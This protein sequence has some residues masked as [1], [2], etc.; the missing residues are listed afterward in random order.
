MHNEPSPIQETLRSIGES[1]VAGD[2]GKAA[3]Q[4]AQALREGAVDADLHYLSGLVALSAGQPEAAVPHFTNAIGLNDRQPLYHLLMGRAL[5][6]AGKGADAAIALSRALALAPASPDARLELAALYLR[7]G[8]RQAAKEA[9]RHIGTLPA[10]DDESLGRLG[11][12][13]TELGDHLA[14]IDI[15]RR[16]AANSPHSAHA[17]ADLGFSLFH[18]GNPT[19][20]LEAL[21]TAVRIAPHEAGHWFN[22]GVAAQAVGQIERAGDA[23]RFA[24]TLAPGHVDA[25]M[26]LGLLQMQKY[27]HEGARRTFESALRQS[28]GNSRLLFNLAIALAALGEDEAADTAF[29]Q[30]A[31]QDGNGLYKALHLLR[32]PEVVPVAEEDLTSERSAFAERI[33]EL[34]RYRLSLDELASIG[35]SWFCLAYHGRNNRDLLSGLCRAFRSA[36]PELAY[37]ARHCAAPR[38]PGRIRV[39]FVSNHL[40]SHTVGLYFVAFIQVLDPQEF[41]VSVFSQREPAHAV[42]RGIH[43]HAAEQV[44]LARS[45]AVARDQ[46][47]AKDLDIL[48]YPDIGMEPMSYFMAFA[49]LAP[50]QVALYGHPET[51]GIDTIDRFLSHAE[52]ETEG[53]AAHYSEQLLLMPDR[54]AYT[55]FPRSK[56]GRTNK[57]REQFGFRHDDVLFTCLQSSHKIHPDFDALADE[58][59]GLE[60][61]A[62]LILFDG[63]GPSMKR[64]VARMAQRMG[65]RADR[66]RLL[67]RQGFGDYLAVTAFS[68]VI[69][70]TPHFNGG[71]TTFDALAMHRP[72]VTMAG[73]TLKNRQ[74]GHLLRRIGLPELVAST[75]SGYVTAALNAANEREQAR[76]ADRMRAGEARVFEDRASAEAFQDLLTISCS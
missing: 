30:S 4:C 62:K 20:A 74:T 8:D 28:P 48:V 59:L 19:Q 69:L 76:I 60:P 26:S 13:L 52:C 16:L 41:E 56:A 58:I 21:D 5:A 35:T 36:C 23:F 3:N 9:C 53:S 39:G 75:E 61:R 27:D 71:K 47:A 15:R 43:P 54:C 72:I 22:F 10:L 70:D 38:R 45:L 44:I 29:R 40:N 65:E 11:N 66:I 67:P 49:R 32:L 63:W 2:L 31:E 68:D 17:H 55:C 64:V 24:T 50:M 25:T 51:T 6:A 34:G 18:A 14:A 37:T 46:V 12:L 73:E 42:S 7:M 1:I 57:S 33:E